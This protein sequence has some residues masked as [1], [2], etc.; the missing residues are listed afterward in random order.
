MLFGRWVDGFRDGAEVRE[1][2]L[3][4]TEVNS[5]PTELK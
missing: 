5:E 2:K 3:G 4:I 1:I